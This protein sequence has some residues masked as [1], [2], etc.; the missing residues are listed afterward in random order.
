[1]IT[2]S[3]LKKFI[4]IS[5]DDIAILLGILILVYLFAIDYF[6]IVAIVACI[7]LT[8]FL[9]AKYIL[10]AP[11]LDETPRTNYD[12]VG[13]IGTALTDIKEEGIVLIM[14]E[15]WKAKSKNEQLIPAGTRVKVIRRYGLFLVV[16]AVENQSTF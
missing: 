16:E 4:I 15:R 9:I 8:T 3:K 1:V 2:L 5:L 12:L 6:M 7:G 14:N 13:K 10:L 11:V